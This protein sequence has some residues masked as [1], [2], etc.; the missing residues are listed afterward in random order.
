MGSFDGKLTVCDSGTLAE[1]A[2]YNNEPQ[3]LDLS[4]LNGERIAAALGG[5]LAAWNVPGREVPLFARRSS[6]ARRDTAQVVVSGGD[7]THGLAAG[8]GCGAIT[9][10]DLSLLLRPECFDPV[11]AKD[12]DQ[13][14]KLEVSHL[15]ERRVAA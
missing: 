8:Y 11:A 10:W 9:R 4:W 5:D 15:R 12:L 3:V 1:I 13:A 6:R 7:A 2:T 14:H